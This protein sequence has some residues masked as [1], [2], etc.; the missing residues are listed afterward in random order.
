MRRIFLL[1]SLLFFT[2]CSLTGTS[3]QA[4]SCSQQFWNGTVAACL[5]SGWRII[6]REELLRLG[7]P[8]ETVAAFQN[9]TPH[10]GQLDTIT[11]TKEPLNSDLSTTDYSAASVLAVSSLP[12]YSLIDTQTVTIDGK[13]AQLHVFS[14]RPSPDSA[15]RRYYQVSAVHEKVGYSFTGSFPLSVTESEAAQ[16]VFI[17]KNV[18][19]SDPKGK[20]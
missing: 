1:S 5:P 8:E 6:A 20:K 11:V 12:D 15:L 17:L 9:D 10:A 13:S 2:A 18:S 19:F 4:V 7:L 16:V 14:S 3:S